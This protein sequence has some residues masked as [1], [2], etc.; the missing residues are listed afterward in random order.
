MRVNSETLSDLIGHIYDCALDQSHW[1][2]T[3]ERLAAV[4]DACNGTILSH[5]TH[6]VSF[7]YH[8]G[9]P[10]EWMQAYA[11]KHSRI[12]PLLTIGWHFDVDEPITM[13]LF[14]DPDE[15]RK[16][17]FHKEFL[18]PLDWFHFIAVILQKSATQ[19]ATMG[20]TRRAER[21]LPSHDDKALIRLLAPHVRRATIFHAIVERDAAR[22]TD[23]AAALD[24]L[25]TP[26]LLFDADGNCIETNLAAERFLAETDA[27]RWDGKQIRTREGPKDAQIAV[28]ARRLADVSGQPMSFALTQTDG[29]RFAAH[30]LPLSG[31][32][33]ER[34]GGTPRA[35][36]AMFV[37]AIGE[38]QPLPGEVLVKLYGL[39]T[40][41]TRL[42]GLLARDH[43]LEESA[44]ALGIARTTARTHLKHIF[45]KTGTN[46][47]SQLMKLVLSA[48][49]RPPA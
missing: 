26:V 27:L 6:N 38:L 3:L 9:T 39:T 8:W 19:T 5:G 28:S 23:L 37:Q 40:A 44:S 1:V 11:E 4:F 36:S 29:R 47:Q 45:E 35:V 22:A 14:M 42:I 13:D 12:D 7:Q 2:P 43:T 20:F 48:L 46:R 24:L 21:D 30:V 49:P 34:M 18:A 16:T 33:R 32:F 41:E 25:Q 31:G 15:L 10:P 17:R